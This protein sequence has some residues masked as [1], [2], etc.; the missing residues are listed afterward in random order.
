MKFNTTLPQGYTF[1]LANENELEKALVFYKSLLNTPGNCWDEDYPN[2]EILQDDIAHGWLYFL[3]DD[4][5]EIAAA[6]VVTSEM[7]DIEIP[8]WDASITNPCVLAR[9]GVATQHQGRGF[10]RLVLW[11]CIEAAAELGNDGMLLLVAAANKAAVA[12]Y[13]H[14]GFVKHDT[15]FLYDIWFDCYDMPIDIDS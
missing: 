5:D 7:E 9:L 6:A 12:L 2:R 11:L 10:G 4:N 14:A 8:F 3:C 13:E 15:V 1:R